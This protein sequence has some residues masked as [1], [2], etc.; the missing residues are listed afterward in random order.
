MGKWCR[1]VCCQR[2]KLGS[3]C[4]VL[5][6]VKRLKGSDGGRVLPLRVYRLCTKIP[7]AFISLTLEGVV[8]TFWAATGTALA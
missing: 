6:L 2:G 4:D 7:E 1:K 5:G 3:S 8:E